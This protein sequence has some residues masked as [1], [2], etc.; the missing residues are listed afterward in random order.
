MRGCG[1]GRTRN[2]GEEGIYNV[3]F[4]Y[5]EE[6]AGVYAARASVRI[7]QSLVDA[8]EYNLAEDIQLGAAGNSLGER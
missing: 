1:F 8:T 7:A 5:V 2:V 6:D 3:V 4:D